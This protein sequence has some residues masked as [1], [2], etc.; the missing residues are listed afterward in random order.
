MLANLLFLTAAE[1]TAPS[2]FETYGTVIFLVLML[3]VMYFTVVI[4]QRK[5]EK[6]RNE[7][8]NS[9]EVGDG[10]VTIGGIVGR[11]VSIKDDTVLIETGS[12]RVKI[13]MSKN[14]IGEVEKLNLNDSKSDSKE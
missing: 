8:R 7:L 12:D 2:F 3:A 13:R 4:P 9:L 5:E 10:V 6:A 1:S 11:V 14:A